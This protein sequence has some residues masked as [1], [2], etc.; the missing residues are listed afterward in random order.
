MML[1]QTFQRVN[2]TG[3]DKTGRHSGFL[4]YFIQ[5]EKCVGSQI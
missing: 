2:F 4:P 1:S 5:N 3:K